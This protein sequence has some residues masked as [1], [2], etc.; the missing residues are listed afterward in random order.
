MK[1]LLLGA[2]VLFA[3]A[4]A[5]PANAEPPGWTWNGFYIGVNA[6]YAWS[7][8]DVVTT[9]GNCC[10]PSSQ[11]ELAIIAADS[12]SLK[13]SGFT[14]GGQAGINYQRGHVVLGLEG[15]VNSFHASASQTTGINILDGRRFVSTNS[16]NT[17]WLATFRARGGLAFD[18]LLIYATGGGALTRI[19]YNTQESGSDGNLEIAALSNTRVGWVVGG[20]LEYAF[21]NNWSLKGE[22]LHLDFG[23][24]STAGPNIFMGVWDGNIYFHDVRL[25]SNIVRAGLNYKFGGP[26]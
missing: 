7:T 16:I 14:G 1:K 2:V 9:G 25:R 12:A 10:R 20:G 5:G 13:P 26:Y 21:A 17:D 19:S 3:L 6:G 18:R 24:V 15:D 23:H 8:V 11:N 4:A 22:Y